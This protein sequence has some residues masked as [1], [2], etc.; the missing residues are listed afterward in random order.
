MQ[1]SFDV[2]TVVSVVGNFFYLSARLLITMKIAA[3]VRTRRL[4]YYVG[5][6]LWREKITLCNF[7]LFLPAKN[8]KKEEEE[9][10][11]LPDLLRDHSGGRS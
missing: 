1:H 9:A 4:H 8:K 6:L 10:K 11:K 3:Y 7:L 2:C 5:S